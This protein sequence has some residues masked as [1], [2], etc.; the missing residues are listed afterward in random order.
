MFSTDSPSAQD[1]V[2]LGHRNQ[3]TGYSTQLLP[4]SLS[5]HGGWQSENLDKDAT[6]EMISSKNASS[7]SLSFV[8]SEFSTESPSFQP[9]DRLLQTSADVDSSYG[10][11]PTTELEV[12]YGSVES[13]KNNLSEN[14]GRS[15]TAK[16]LNGREQMLPPGFSGKNSLQSRSHISAKFSNREDSEISDSPVLVLLEDT[17][18]TQQ[19]VQDILAKANQQSSRSHKKTR[20]SSNSPSPRK[21]A[22]SWEHTFVVQNKFKDAVSESPPDRAL[23][24][25]GRRRGPLRD[26]SKER[27]NT[28]RKIGSCRPCR[29]A[30]IA[31]SCLIYLKEHCT[32]SQ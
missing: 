19:E 9:K 24:K 15:M 26:D 21:I 14:S 3:L 30:K 18:E 31:A 12:V 1:W 10:M 25:S 4:R 27:T 2:T 16:D 17:N 22:P 23:Q 28:M 13:E 29:I 8:S 7:S 32:N 5:Q 6:G 11:L 20:N